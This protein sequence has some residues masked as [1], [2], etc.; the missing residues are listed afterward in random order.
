MSNATAWAL[1]ALSGLVDVAWA[2]ATK[3]ADGF[4]QPGWAAV[5]LLLLGLF[6]VLLTRALQVLPLGVAYAVW[7]GIG[8][9]GATA[10]GILLFGEPVQP[11]RLAFAAIV[12]IGVAGLKLA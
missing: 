4:R 3:K 1:L 11:A 5:S 2:I 7:V 9:V 12:V 8:A 6:V 10:A